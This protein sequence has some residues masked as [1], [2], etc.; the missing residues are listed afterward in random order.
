MA[1]AVG[2]RPQ[3]GEQPRLA[4]PRLALDRDRDPVPVSQLAQKPA[5]PI[6]LGR[7]ADGLCGPE[8]HRE[9]A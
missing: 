8:C 5:Q 6:E 9:R 3:V 7:A 1:A 4:N 2:E